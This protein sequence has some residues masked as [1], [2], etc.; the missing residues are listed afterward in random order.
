MSDKDD[1]R[2]DVVKQARCLSAG[3]LSYLCGSTLYTV[4]DQVRNDFVE[5]CE[6][7]QAHY[8]SW[9]AAWNDYAGLKGY[10]SENK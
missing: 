1:H 8:Q 9:Q 7:T 3:T 10:K 5:Y 2:E 6:E 4:V